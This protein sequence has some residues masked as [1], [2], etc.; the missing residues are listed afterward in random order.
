M[1]FFLSEMETKLIMEAPEETA[2]SSHSDDSSPT[3]QGTTSK[4]PE[5]QTT[6]KLAF[7]KEQYQSVLITFGITNF[8]FNMGISVVI[9]F[10]PPLANEAVGLNFS[11]IGW[12]I[13]CSPLGSIFGGILIAPKL[14]VL[15]YSIS[16][17]PRSQK[18]AHWKFTCASICCLH[19]WRAEIH[20]RLP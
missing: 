9:P 20:D 14:D 13:S 18:F 1:T 11:T 6:K 12:V 8:I 15:F 19:V 5:I 7:S 2:L 10:Y 16:V 3:R 4:C 17:D